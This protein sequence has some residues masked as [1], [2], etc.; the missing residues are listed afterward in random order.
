[1]DSIVSQVTGK[2]PIIFKTKILAYFCRDNLEL[3]DV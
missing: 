1:M 2:N 3:V